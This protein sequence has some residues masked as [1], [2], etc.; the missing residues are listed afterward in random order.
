[1]TTP[2]KA[3]RLASPLSV[4]AATRPLTLTSFR[5]R[6][7]FQHAQRAN[8][9]TRQTT[10]A[11]LAR[12]L[13]SPAQGPPIP[14]PSVVL[15][16]SS[17]STTALVARIAPPVGSPTQPTICAIRASTTAKLAS[18]QRPHAPLASRRTRSSTNISI[19]KVACRVAL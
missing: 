3:A 16:S 8:S 4:P 2:V 9:I 14:A 7:V 5:G 6:H 11:M 13:V 18:S 17:T 15:T 1:V 12:R 10:L 19:S